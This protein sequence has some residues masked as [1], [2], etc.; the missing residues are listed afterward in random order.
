MRGKRVLIVE[1]DPTSQDL[2]IEYLDQLGLEG[3]L[4]KNGLEA[5]D[6][7]RDIRPDVI[8]LDL[9]MPRL[10]GLKFLEERKADPV[11]QACAVIV[12]SAIGQ[13]EKVREAI[14]K[15]AN[16]YIRKPVGFD[17]F[18]EKLNEHLQR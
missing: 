14:A 9:M 11:L 1:D 3:Y 17:T 5:L 16:D 4:A 12:T 13:V 18:Q 2:M 6:V 7:A 10:D 8:L 15:G